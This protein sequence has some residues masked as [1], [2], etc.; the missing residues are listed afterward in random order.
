MQR[1]NVRSEWVVCAIIMGG[2]VTISCTPT[3][4]RSTGPRTPKIPGR[5]TSS[6]HLPGG[7]TA[8]R[9]G[10]GGVGRYALGEGKQAGQGGVCSALCV[11]L[12]Y[13]Y[14]G[15]CLRFSP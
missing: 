1:K 2:V 10:E 7:G 14:R 9:G 4:L 11:D 12:I 8:S 13:G 15:A 5:S 3:V 6:F